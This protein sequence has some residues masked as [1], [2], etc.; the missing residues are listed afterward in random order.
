MGEES[1]EANTAT[2]PHTRT[3]FAT[4]SSI[5]FAVSAECAASSSFALLAAAAAAALEAAE[6]ATFAVLAGLLGVV[7]AAAAGSLPAGVGDSP[8]PCTF[9]SAFRDSIAWYCSET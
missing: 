5:S 9:N 6:S 3:S 2:K 8:P 7:A 1:K 4:R